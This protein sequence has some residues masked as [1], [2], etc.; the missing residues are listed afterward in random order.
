[1]TRDDEL[2][3]FF[4]AVLP[5]REPGVPPG[6]T[7]RARESGLRWRRRRRIHA[8]LATASV[9]GVLGPVGL[10]I[11]LVDRSDHSSA[12]ADGPSAEYMGTF[13][14]FVDAVQRN[15][16]ED[17][18]KEGR[19][20]AWRSVVMHAVGVD[21]PMARISLTLDNRPYREF[22]ITVGH[23]GLRPTCPG[24]F[25][26]AP[27]TC[28][29]LKSREVWSIPG[30]GIV[31]TYSVDGRIHADVYLGVRGGRSITLTASTA[32]D[33]GMSPAPGTD[34]SRSGDQFT[35]LFRGEA[36]KHATE[37]LAR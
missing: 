20:G 1:M 8:A 16:V 24:D 9:V 26:L 33:A 5:E 12:A 3:E 31:K 32:G 18:P 6:M 21:Q 19:T 23:D 36:A 34:T 30:S 17:A 14:A 2:T 7:E 22:D 11:G 29:D 27:G 15:I 37:L 4:R 28:G 35:A 25:P 13:D 10:G